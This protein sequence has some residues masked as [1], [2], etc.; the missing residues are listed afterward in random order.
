MQKKTTVI[1]V[2]NDFTNS[3]I[4]GDSVNFGFMFRYGIAFD[5]YQEKYLPYMMV[6]DREGIY[7]LFT[8]GKRS[9]TYFPEIKKFNQAD[10]LFF[11][12][13]NG[14]VNRLSFE[15]AINER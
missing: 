11:E 5:V 12:I 1:F 9:L 3:S 14:R 15:E 6:E 8:D 7:S 13:N 2:Q 4:F 10:A